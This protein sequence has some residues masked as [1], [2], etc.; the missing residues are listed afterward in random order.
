M[1]YTN[2]HERNLQINKIIEL[3]SNKLPVKVNEIEGE[4]IFLHGA[5]HFKF[6]DP[7]T[8]WIANEADVAAIINQLK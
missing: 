6:V 1:I 7:K 3:V 4:Q 2:N 8:K 5:K